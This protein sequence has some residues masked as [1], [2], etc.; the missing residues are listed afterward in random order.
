MRGGFGVV[1]IAGI[2]GCL[3]VAPCVALAQEPEARY[4]PLRE[5]NFPVPV[6]KIQSMNPRPTKLRFFASQDRGAFKRVAEKAIGDLEVID[7]ERN[8]RGFRFVSPA[9]GDYE[10][11]L[12]FVYAD[13]DLQPRDSDL[14]GQYRIIFDTRPPLVRIAASG[15]TGVEWS[16][17][18]E[19]LK[20]DGVQLEVR[21]QG[22]QQWTT[23]TPRTFNPRDRYTWAAIPQDKVLEVRVVGRDKAGL[24]M[25]S[26]IITL[27]TRGN[28]SGLGNDDGGAPARNASRTTG[29]TDDVPNRPEVQYVNTNNLT[30][31]S[32]LTRVTRSGV[33]SADLW[34]NDGRS[35][36]KKDKSQVVNIQASDPDPVVKIPYVAQKDGLYGFIV[37]PVNGAGGKQDDP[38]PND[39]AHI[40]VYVDTEK[41]VVQ[42][43]GVRVSPGGTVG[44]RVEIEWMVTETNLMPDPIVIEYAEDKNSTNWKPIAAKIPNTGRYVWEVED[45]NLW[46]FYVRVAAVD[47]ASNRGEAV[48]DKEV[49]VDLEKPQA[50][51]EKVQ[52]GGGSV[53]PAPKPA[54]SPAPST[55]PATIPEQLSE[56]PPATPAP[57]SPSAPTV[58][59]IPASSPK[60]PAPVSPASLPGGNDPP[61]VPVLPPLGK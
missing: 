35:G 40:L 8:R 17:E 42:V 9:D 23:I 61:P 36:W 44:P 58:P 49:I 4:W 21:Y 57:K 5:I 22:R 53:S 39:S 10:F 26:R 27:P 29:L 38:Q 24:E 47:K 32:K 46:R 13:G 50:V 30:V 6:D 19:N 1:L 48:Y 54:P 14:T 15:A 16:V 37:I 7:N 31:E 20:P 34:V 60:T 45:K 52:S 33:R 28:A 56:K 12:Q 41:P 11:A 51:I 59:T 55:P 43:K 18:D 2:V 3:A 25:A